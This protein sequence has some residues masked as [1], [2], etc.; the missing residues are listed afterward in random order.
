MVSTYLK[1]YN[2][3]NK[4]NVIDKFIWVKYIEKILKNLIIV[5]ER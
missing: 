3:W 1:I 2:Y 5:V 4:I